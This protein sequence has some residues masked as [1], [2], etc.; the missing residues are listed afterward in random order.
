[1]FTVTICSLKQKASHPCEA[2][3]R[4]ALALSM[5]Q[6]F[7]QRVMEFLGIV[8]GDVIFH[9]GASHQFCAGVNQF[10]GDGIFAEGDS[11]CEEGESIA[12]IFQGKAEVMC[13]IGDADAFDAC[14]GDCLAMEPFL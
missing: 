1:M 9:S 10:H 11:F 14:V 8:L 6:S 12:C 2:F 3:V 5:V 13:F 4:S 7:I